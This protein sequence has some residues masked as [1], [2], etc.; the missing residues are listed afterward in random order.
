M[1]DKDKKQNISE[2]LEKEVP[3][4]ALHSLALD[5]LEQ[6]IDLP[7]GPEPIT[8][9]QDLVRED[10][11]RPEIH[12][13]DS[14]EDF[15]W[16]KEAFLKQPSVM[17]KVV[18]FVEAILGVSI[19]SLIYQ[20]G[21]TSNKSYEGVVIDPGDVFRE[22]VDQQVV[23]KGFVGHRKNSLEDIERLFK[24]GHY[25]VEFDVRSGPS[26]EFYLHHDPLEDH[27][28]LEKKPSL[29]KLSEV[30][31]LLRQYPQARPFLEVKGDMNEARLLVEVF[32]KEKALSGASF[33]DRFS[34]LSFN[35][36][37]LAF[38][39]KELSEMKE[40]IHLN[41]LLFCYF[42]LKGDLTMHRVFSD[43]SKDEL[44]ESLDMFG[45]PNLADQIESVH[46]S[47]FKGL[48]FENENDSLG[49]MEQLCMYDVLPPENILEKVKQSNGY[50]AVPWFL[51]REWSGFF[52][53]ARQKG[54]QVAVFGF[55][56]FR[57]YEEETNRAIAM[58][59]NLAIG[60]RVRFGMF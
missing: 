22:S 29:T 26:G 49:G 13:Q 21:I 36:Y 5:Q 18:E 30:F 12:P 59:A 55:E 37:V 16:I 41:P 42:P 47:R 25:E 44:V 40:S 39:Q 32:R 17:L 33:L 28:F 6:R 57:D 50:L 34:F 20:L 9:L 45:R 54:V 52:E 3:A 56:Y 51:V 35:P 7:V 46:L 8:D 4:Q 31:D 14:L 53:A 38:L 60:D 2:V 48:D 23:E 10:F 24:K 43:F 27:D 1:S 11:H 58:G 19:G 15:L